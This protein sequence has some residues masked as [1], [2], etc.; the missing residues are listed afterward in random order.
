M[1]YRNPTRTTGLLRSAAR[2]GSPR[3]LAMPTT[4]LALQMNASIA[5]D[6]GRLWTGRPHGPQKADAPALLAELAITV[7][8][9]TMSLTRFTQVLRRASKNRGSW[10][11]PYS[12]A[13]NVVTASPPPDIYRPITIQSIT[14]SKHPPFP[15]IATSQ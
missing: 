13:P 5:V 1:R 8:S 14:T 9:Y 11:P 4:T 2:V 6:S 15:T 3:V 12:E 10:I 7:S